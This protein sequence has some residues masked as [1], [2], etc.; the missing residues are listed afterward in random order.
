MQVQ[1]F[2]RCWTLKEAFIK[3]KGQGLSIPLDQFDVSFVPGEPVRLLNTQW[4]TREAEQWTL[5]DLDFGDDYT[6][7]IA[8]EGHGWKMKCLSWL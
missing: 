4:N 8:I 7:A 3:A 1:A 5:R 2:F 6:S